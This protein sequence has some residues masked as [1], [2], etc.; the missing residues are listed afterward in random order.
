MSAW[1]IA[2]CFGI[3]L[4]L[5]LRPTIFALV[6]ESRGKANDLLLFAYFTC[7]HTDP[8]PHLRKFPVDPFPPS[9]P[10]FAIVDEFMKCTRPFPRGVPTGA[11]V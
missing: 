2:P 11:G 7:R 9:S 4:K 1:V 3:W 8:P 10:A 6:P 5:V